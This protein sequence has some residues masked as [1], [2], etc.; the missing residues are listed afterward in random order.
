MVA[1]TDATDDEIKYAVSSDIYSG[2]GPDSFQ[3]VQTEI[4]FDCK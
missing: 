3:L 1:V 2:L 4:V